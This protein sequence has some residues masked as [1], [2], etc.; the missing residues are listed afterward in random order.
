[1]N[2]I[3][4]VIMDLYYHSRFLYSMFKKCRKLY[5]S[6]M[7]LT[8]KKF[9]SEV[10]KHAV[11]S[12]KYDVPLK[13]HSMNHRN[14][15][16]HIFKM[17]YKYNNEIKII[18]IPNNHKYVK[19]LAES[20]EKKG[21]DVNLFPSFSYATPGNFVK[22]I[23][24]KFK[25]YKIIH[26]QWVYVF[27]FDW[28]M[29]FYVNLSKKLG[30]KIVWS[31]HDIH[32]S[33]LESRFSHKEKML[34]MYHAA[35]YKF[36]HYK[37]NIELL[38]KQLGVEPTDI[39]V[40]YHPLF[41]ESYPNHV[42]QKEARRLL[43]IPEN[44]KVLLLFG[45]IAKYKGVDLFAKALRN[46]N[47]NYYGL[48]VGRKWDKNLIKDVKE[49]D[50]R[51]L[52]IIDEY[53]PDEEVQHYFN[54]CDVVVAPYISITTSG[55]VLLAFSFRKPVI[56]TNLGGMPEVVVNGKT[57]LLIPSNDAEA[58]VTAIKKIFTM[59]YQKM[60]ENAYKLA[61]EKFTWEKLA[62]QTIK[63]Y[64]KVLENKNK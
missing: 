49:R 60:G 44:K 24:L 56:T 57:G 37:S 7:V 41:D 22:T 11:D 42:T 36:I 19:K 23:L 62:E 6:I 39:E 50:I 35:D 3:G 18:M 2:E 27:P 13:P 53:I 55:V 25:G 61:S 63:I 10:K 9:W 5:I 12:F 59:D 15:K 40:V 8:T 4:V 26:I 38:K 43:G 28:L 16:D 30:Y 33:A 14:F 51:N 29:K 20:M 21:V 45:K 46:L 64:E 52:K 58:L 54:A 32:D 47:G 17:R 34:W 1:M 31:I 48:I